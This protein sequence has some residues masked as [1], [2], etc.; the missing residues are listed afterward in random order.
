VWLEAIIG[1]LLGGRKSPPKPPES[2][3]GKSI[4]L[5]PQTF[6]PMLKEQPSPKLPAGMLASYL[7][8]SHK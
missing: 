4:P 7:K 1:K 2:R 3:P 5:Y 8:P 6:I